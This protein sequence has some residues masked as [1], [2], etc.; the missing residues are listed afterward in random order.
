MEGRPRL[1]VLTT[2]HDPD[3]PR[4]R[5]RTLASLAEAFDVTY[6]TR[7]P[8][9]TRG[10]DHSW[11]ELRGGRVRRWFGALRLLVA[12]RYDVAS[13]HDPEL[14]PAALA[15]RLLRR[16]R[17]VVDVHEHVPGQILHKDWVWR[18]L[19]RPVAW[20]ARRSLRLAERFLDVTLAEDGY[21][22]LFRHR[23][24]VF[25]NHP[26][27]GALPAPSPDGGLM[28]YVGV[29]NEY[30]GATLMV[31]AAA[32]LAR[33]LPLV[34]V[35]RVTD[36]KAAELRDLA[37][38]R[39]VDL[40]LAGPKPHREAMEAAAAGTV[41]LALMA[42][43]PNNRWSQPTKLWEY[44]GMGVPLVASR[45]PGTEAA[46]EGYE[47][48]RLVPPGDAAAAAAAIDEIAADPSIREAA[49]AQAPSIAE[50]LVWPAGEV[51]AHYLAL[52]GR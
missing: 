4:V 38:R 32:A 14:I 10:G 37:A 44:L 11:V 18:P 3:D 24:R 9:P 6:A 41:G 22:V 40:T 39:G 5:E 33:P 48:V 25:P 43:V 50:G 7:P 17:I 46:M 29:V 49:A 12:G 13:V 15:A 23:H 30:R 47:A 35:G 34:M 51:R 19:R 8:G 1:L 26:A 20:L 16:R 2:V 27:D 31:E 52:A 42:D 21:H 36:E 45:L 28:A